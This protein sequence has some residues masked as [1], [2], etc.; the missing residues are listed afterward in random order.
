MCYVYLYVGVFA[1]VGGNVK[2]GGQSVH[3]MPWFITTVYCGTGDTVSDLQLQ[4]WE[5]GVCNVVQ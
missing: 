4:G 5:G 3:L 2:V 1:F